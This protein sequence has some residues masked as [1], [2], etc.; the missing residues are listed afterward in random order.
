MAR[1]VKVFQT[2]NHAYQISKLGA[3]KEGRLALLRAQRLVGSAAGGIEKLMASLSDED[4]EYFVSLFTK[5]TRLVQADK[6]PQLALVFDEHFSGEDGFFEMTR[7]LSFCLGFN[8]GPFFLRVLQESQL[9]KAAVLE[10]AGKSAN[11][12]L[13]GSSGESSP[14]AE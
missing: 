7:W 3:D 13:S 14:T 11:P 6:K 4:F 8:F 2:E 12:E 9:L 1:E 5:Y 10:G